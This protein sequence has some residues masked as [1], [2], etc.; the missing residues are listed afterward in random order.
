MERDPGKEVGL[1]ILS[2]RRVLLNC[3]AA[4][5]PGLDNEMYTVE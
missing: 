2:Y 4:S 5:G 1:L 3:K